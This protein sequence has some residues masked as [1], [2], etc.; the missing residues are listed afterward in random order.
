MKYASVKPSLENTE[1]RNSVSPGVAARLSS[2]RRRNTETAALTYAGDFILPSIFSDDTPRSRISGMR[3]ASDRSRRL[4]GYDV[5]PP[6]VYGSLQ[7]CAHS[8]LLPDLPPTRDEK[9]HC[10]EHETQSAPCTKISVS[11]PVFATKYLM[12]SRLISLAGT[13]REK[14]ASTSRRPPSALCTDI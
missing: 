4:S 9:R 7:G 13:M 11:A 6:T 3:L 10:P 14:P 1:E 12:S 5:L 8:P 2:S